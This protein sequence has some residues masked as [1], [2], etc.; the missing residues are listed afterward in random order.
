M[1]R[2]SG[3]AW[4][5]RKLR[6]YGGYEWFRFEVPIG[7]RGDI[8]D[9]AAQH[10]EEMWQSLGIVEQCLQNM[11][12]G[13]YKS[14]HPLATPPRKERTLQDI[15]TL[16]DHFLAVSWG[17]VIPPGEACVP[18]EAAKGNQ[19]YYLISDGGTGS[20]RTRIRT[21]SFAHLQMVSWLS[22]GIMVPD[23]TALL[24]SIDYVLADVDR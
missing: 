5:L 8:Y 23:L 3:L 13:P 1:L 22:R 24:G 2:A 4:D 12:A 16:I 6:P 14:D 9:R 17:P 21:P 19:S 20:Y 10:V 18:A 15:E 7:R 11:P